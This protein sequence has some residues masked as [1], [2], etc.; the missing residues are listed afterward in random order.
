MTNPLE[1]TWRVRAS[2]KSKVSCACF[3][4]QGRFHIGMRYCTGSM[5]VPGDSLESSIIGPRIPNSSQLEIGPGRRNAAK[6]SRQ[7]FGA[8]LRNTRLFRETCQSFRKGVTANGV[9]GED[10]LGS[11]VQP[12]AESAISK[13][14]WIASQGREVVTFPPVPDEEA[15]IEAR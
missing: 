9:N 7:K 6:C 12:L 11:G 2:M 15:E 14:R 5:L 1:S 13:H 3:V 8:V 4:G 10:V